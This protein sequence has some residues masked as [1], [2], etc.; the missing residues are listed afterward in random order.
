MSKPSFN[1][2]EDNKFFPKLETMPHIPVPCC[3]PCFLCRLGPIVRDPLIVTFDGKFLLLTLSY[4]AKKDRPSGNVTR[5]GVT[6]RLN[7]ILFI[8]ISSTSMRFTSKYFFYNN[9]T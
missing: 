4:L 1:A 2:P 3:V 9:S 7:N 8:Y 6:F 5:C